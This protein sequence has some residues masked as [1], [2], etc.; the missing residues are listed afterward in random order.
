MSVGSTENMWLVVGSTDY[1]SRLATSIMCRLA[2]GST[3]HMSRMV[4][5]KIYWLV[6][7]KMYRLALLEICRFAVG[8]T[9]LISRMVLLTICRMAALK[10]C[11]LVA[12]KI[13]YVV[14]SWEY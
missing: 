7:L 2:V 4:I 13:L 5:L 10:T 6:T 14:G 11:W 9:D 8:S 12:P 1:V 3:D